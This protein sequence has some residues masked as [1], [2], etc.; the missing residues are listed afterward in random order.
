METRFPE[1]RFRL[2]SRNEASS[3]SRLALTTRQHALSQDS[4]MRSDQ[5]NFHIFIKCK[6]LIL[7]DIM[8]KRRRHV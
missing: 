6:Q 1:T 8:S 4:L 7:I 3:H 2:H 5:G